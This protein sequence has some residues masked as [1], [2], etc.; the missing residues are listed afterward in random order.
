M[1]FDQLRTLLA[2][3]EHGSFTRAAEALG[4]SQSTVS[5]HVKGLESSVGARLL[6]RGRDGVRATPSGELLRGYAERL[7]TLRG[8][9][10]EALR[11]ESHGQRGRVVVAAST[12]PGEYLLPPFLARLRLSHPGVSVRV[13]VSES[14][15]ALAS[16]MA[17]ECDLA[18]VGRRPPDRALQA[19]PFAEDEVVL[20]GPSPNPFVVPGQSFDEEALRRVPLVLRGEGS[21]TRAAVADILS[22]VA[23]DDDGPARTVV[24]STE[25]AKRCVLAGMGLSFVSR[26]AV[27]DELAAGRMELVPLPG[28]P[29]AR[30]FWVVVLRDRTP[31]SATA[32]LVGLLRAGASAR[33]MAAP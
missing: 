4:L 3:L 6:D 32:A 17:R 28:T 23:V 11:A 1:E 14:S 2:V 30:R 5:F 16:L 29:V 31:S 21:G 24:G 9:A 33:V 25:A 8:E 22:R 10:V 18:L 26:H 20:V 27:A 19:E 12:I 15:R 13:E 7:W